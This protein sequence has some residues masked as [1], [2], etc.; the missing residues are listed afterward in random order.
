MFRPIAS[1]E[2]PIWGMRHKVLIDDEHIDIEDSDR[3][4]EPSDIRPGGP[5]LILPLPHHAVTPVGLVI[6][7]LLMCYKHSVKPIGLAVT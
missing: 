4:F 1:C 7:S 2:D 6:T 5:G 3:S